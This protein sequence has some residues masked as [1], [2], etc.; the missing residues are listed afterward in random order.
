MAHQAIA[1]GGLIP[2]EA[3]LAK[4]EPGIQV[5]KARFFLREVHALQ[6]DTVPGL[7][8]YKGQRT[9]IEWPLTINDTRNQMHT[10]QQCLDLPR[11]VRKC[12]P[13][14]NACMISIS[15]TLHLAVTLMQSNGTVSEV[16]SR[17]PL[18]NPPANV[19]L[20]WSLDT[21]YSIRFTRVTS[22]WLGHL[23]AAE[24]ELHQQSARHTRGRTSCSTQVLYRR[25]ENG[26]LREHPWG[27]SAI[28]LRTWSRHG[29]N[30]A[31]QLVWCWWPPRAA[32]YLRMLVEVQINYR[33]SQDYT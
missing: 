1:L 17:N 33:E 26:G 24:S 20:A 22:R 16:A 4:L 12:S 6:D 14:L 3:Q 19:H 21:H 31:N 23:C 10:W 32:I 27:C 28:L 13:D 9:V 7:M 18:L 8:A 15:H 11:V 5:I 29:T 30:A 2:V 25:E